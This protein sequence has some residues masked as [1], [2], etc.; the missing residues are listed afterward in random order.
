MQIKGGAVVYSDVGIYAD[1]ETTNTD[2][3][4]HLGTDAA[5]VPKADT[6]MDRL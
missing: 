2:A 6:A 4:T 5:V 3:S 1:A